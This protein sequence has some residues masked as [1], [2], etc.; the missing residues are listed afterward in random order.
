MSPTQ[1]LMVEQTEIFKPRDSS[2][3]FQVLKF[4]LA[5][6]LP[7]FVGGNDCFEGVGGDPADDEARQQLQQEAVNELG[8]LYNTPARIILTSF[9]A[10]WLN[11]DV[12]AKKMLRIDHCKL[13]FLSN[14]RPLISS[15]NCWNWIKK[16]KEL[17]Y[18]PKSLG[19]LT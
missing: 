8:R 19:N 7:D 10:R 15:N 9:S 16:I 12:C 11:K 14:I 4:A 5:R 13:R 2:T 18:S 17:P 1:I 3:C 6:M